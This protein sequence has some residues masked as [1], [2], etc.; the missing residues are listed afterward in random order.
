MGLVMKNVAVLTDFFLHN[1]PQESKAIFTNPSMG[2]DI[3]VWRDREGVTH[4]QVSDPEDG[5]LDFILGKDGFTQ[6]L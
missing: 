6:K 4:I 1:I 3:T 2:W 5:Q